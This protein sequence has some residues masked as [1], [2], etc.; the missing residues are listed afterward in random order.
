MPAKLSHQSKYKNNIKLYNYLESLEIKPNDWLVI[1]YFYTALHIVES[2][3]A[4]YHKDSGNHIQRNKSVKSMACFREVRNAYMALY[5]ESRA[6]RYDCVEI[7]NQKV[8]NAK[9]NLERI[10]TELLNK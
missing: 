2:I 1:V 7:N 10:I 9:N 4:D 5:F 3:L 8:T 6:A